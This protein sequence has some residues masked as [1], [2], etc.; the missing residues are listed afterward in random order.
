MS[1][2]K[3]TGDVPKQFTGSAA[4]LMEVLFLLTDVYQPEL[5]PFLILVFIVI[6]STEAVQAE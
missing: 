2:S 4:G 5:D 6:Y 3:Q 1:I